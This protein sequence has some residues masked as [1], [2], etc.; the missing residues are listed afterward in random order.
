MLILS[1]HN[2][3]PLHFFY[4][5]YVCVYIYNIS[6][7]RQHKLAYFAPPDPDFVNGF[8][9]SYPVILKRSLKLV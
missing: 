6:N 9:F 8:Y 2:T 3:S 5:K 4:F 7:L 1:I